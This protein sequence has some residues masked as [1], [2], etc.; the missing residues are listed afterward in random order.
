MAVP[1]PGPT[2]LSGQVHVAQSSGGVE[3]RL[4]YCTAAVTA[5][6]SPGRAKSVSSPG[7]A[8]EGNRK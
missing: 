4:L 6:I 3:S 7:G 8:M 2:K 1:S 5:L